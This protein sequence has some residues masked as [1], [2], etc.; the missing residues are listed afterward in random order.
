M[1][2][3]GALA[4]FA[5]GMA[6]A[7]YI[8][9]LSYQVKPTGLGV[10]TPPTVVGLAPLPAVIDALRIDPVTNVAFPNKTKG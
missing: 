3:G 9:T 10:L 7:R 6:S 2:L 4:G 1:A 5:L 8:E